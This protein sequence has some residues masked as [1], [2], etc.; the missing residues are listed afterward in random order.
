MDVYNDK[1]NP[2][3]PFAKVNHIV[4]VITEGVRVHPG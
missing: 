2:K 1:R 4:V 3:V